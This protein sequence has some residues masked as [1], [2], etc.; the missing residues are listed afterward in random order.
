MVKKVEPKAKSKKAAREA[1]KANAKSKQPTPNA[2]TNSE[3]ATQFQAP[4]LPISADKQARLKALADKYIADQITP[5]EYH[6]QR[7]RILAEP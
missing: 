4:P 2:A 6:E 5:A 1:A 7:A 3:T